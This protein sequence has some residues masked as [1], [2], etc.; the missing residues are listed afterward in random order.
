MARICG[1]CGNGIGGTSG[2]TDANVGSVGD[3]E[4]GAEMEL[5][6]MSEDGL[7]RAS[8]VANGSGRSVGG[9]IPCRGSSKDKSGGGLKSEGGA[10]GFDVDDEATDDLRWGSG[11]SADEPCELDVEGDEGPAR[12]EG[13][14]PPLLS[15]LSSDGITHRGESPMVRSRS[16]ERRRE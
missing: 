9:W 8:A 4:A 5:E 10:G 2:G 1:R 15:L 12:D 7:G 11:R 6:L 3:A 13:F 16:M 14:H